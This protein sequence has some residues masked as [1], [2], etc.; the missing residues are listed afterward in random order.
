MSK[1]VVKPGECLESIA[2]KFGFSWKTIW[3]FGE[4]AELKRLR[5]D[6][7]L[8][9]PGDVVVVPDQE[10]RNE[11]IATGAL[12][13]FKCKHMISNLNLQLLENGKPLKEA[14]F[15]LLIDG[16]TQTGKTDANGEIDVKISP[17]AQLGHLTLINSGRK[18]ILELGKLAPPD[19]VTGYQARLKN[20]GYYQG[21]IDG[22]AGEATAKAIASFQRDISQ[23]DTGIADP[24][25]LEALQKA[26]GV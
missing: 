3:N 5:R 15:R 23:N 19:K 2:F 4:N 21:K 16:Q 20:L 1:H 26:H 14:P 6:P 8:M 11:S 9:Y 17:A 24:A 7:N 18:F 10:N 12:H 22:I 25:T 13:R